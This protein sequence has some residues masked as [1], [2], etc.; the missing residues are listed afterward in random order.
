MA[1]SSRLPGQEIG[2]SR[3]AAAGAEPQRRRRVNGKR[4]AGAA[5][6][7]H[8]VDIQLRG[9]T[10]EGRNQMRPR[11]KSHRRTNNDPPSAT[12]AKPELPG[13]RRGRIQDVAAET[14]GTRRHN[15]TVGA[16]TARHLRPRLHRELGRIKRRIKSHLPVLARTV[17]ARRRVT[18]NNPAWPNAGAP[19]YEAARPLPDA[20]A[21]DVPDDSPSRQ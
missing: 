21:A 17:E 6:S 19:R 16:R 13:I 14:R 15:R 8:T 18:R 5:G 10:V 20:S 2:R 3:L 7:Q 1:S 12:R 4:R 11:V 9:R